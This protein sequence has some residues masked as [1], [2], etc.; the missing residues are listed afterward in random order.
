MISVPTKVETMMNLM[1]LPRR[2]QV[3]TGVEVQVHDSIASN[4]ERVL[5]LM[6]DRHIRTRTR[7]PIYMTMA[8]HM[9]PTV[10]RHDDKSTNQLILIW[11]SLE[12]RSN[13]S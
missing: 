10:A 6:Q 9:E 2:I 13:N 11:T 12:A 1:D 5:I 4:R 8:I 7:I 3:V